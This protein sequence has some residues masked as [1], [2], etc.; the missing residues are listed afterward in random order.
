MRGGARAQA[1][2]FSSQTVQLLFSPLS[3]FLDVR[4]THFAARTLGGQ[5]ALPET[6]AA[7]GFSAVP[8][9]LGLVP[10]GGVPALL[11][12]L[13][14]KIRALRILHGFK[15]GRAVAA[16]MASLIALVVVPSAVALLLR[17]FVIEAFK[18]PA[19]SMF[20]SIEVGDHLFV[21]KWSY[22]AFTKTAPT[23]GDVVVFEYPGPAAEARVDY[24]KRVIGI[25][26]DELAFASGVTSING[27]PVPRCRVGAATVALDAM[28]GPEEFEVFVEFLE[29]RAYVVVLDRSRD[30]GH[31]G[32]YRVKPG[33][34]WVL[35]D[36]RNNSFDSRAWD[37]GR[38]AGVPFENSR[39]RAR[40]LWLPPE[41]MGVDLASA[42]VL[43]AN[44]SQL[45]PD[46]ARCLAA[47]PDSAHTR[48]PSPASAN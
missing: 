21:T 16:S 2:L 10:Y 32:P 41:R 31:Q 28:S 30:D 17:G 36:N 5:G 40:W 20:P 3:W 42:P 44:L 25:P 9:A 37:G 11:W 38:G 7:V 29:G 4:L 14:V 12:G 39:G 15:R 24:I 27:W 22:G 1:R 47:A 48:P 45:A 43:P 6:K 33:E 46:V 19:G 13:V 18:V 8:S 35:G 26:G 34:Y 23:R